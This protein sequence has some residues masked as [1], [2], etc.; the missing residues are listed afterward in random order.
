MC[1]ALTLIRFFFFLLNY[2]FNLE[3][4]ESGDFFASLLLPP[5]PPPFFLNV[6]ITFIKLQMIFYIAIKKSKSDFLQFAEK[7]STELQCKLAQNIE[8]YAEGFNCICIT[9][10]QSNVY[11]FAM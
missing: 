7:T 2:C 6:C 5:S 9:I 8:K 4:R 3:W 11:R 10:K 1:I